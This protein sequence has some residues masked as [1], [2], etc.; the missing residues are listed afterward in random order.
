[1]SLGGLVKKQIFG[2]QPGLGWAQESALHLVLPALETL[3]LLPLRQWVVGPHGA[4][5]QLLGTLVYIVWKSSL[6]ALGWVL[7][8]GG[9]E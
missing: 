8:P 1:M 3:T 4:W 9:W 2:F 6:G 5:T 7:N